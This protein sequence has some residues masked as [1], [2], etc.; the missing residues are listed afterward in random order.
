VSTRVTCDCA[1]RIDEGPAVWVVKRSNPCCGQCIL[2]ARTVQLYYWP[3]QATA[4]PTV[5]GLPADVSA[6]VT[7]IPKHGSGSYVDENGFTLYVYKRMS[8][9]ATNDLSISPS[10][11]IGFSSIYG[12]DQCGTVGD[13]SSIVQGPVQPLTAIARY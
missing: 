1:D 11:Y 5:T 2:S 9:S 7:A 4:T 12:T 13:V 10:L 3:N 8:K 6:I